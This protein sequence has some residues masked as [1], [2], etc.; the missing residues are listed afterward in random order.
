M[1][2]ADV[3]NRIVGQRLSDAA[4]QSFKIDDRIVDEVNVVY[5]CFGDWIHIT[6]VDGLSSVRAVSSDKPEEIAPFQTDG[7]FFQ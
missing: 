7:G 3:L 6:S 4:I 2:G 5:L 1:T